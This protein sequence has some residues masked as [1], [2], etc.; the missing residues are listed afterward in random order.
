MNDQQISENFIRK[1]TLPQ[2]VKHGLLRTFRLS[3]NF[4]PIR[5]RR[6]I[7]EFHCSSKKYANYK[8]IF[9]N[10]RPSV[11]AETT[12]APRLPNPRTNVPVR[13]YT[14]TPV[15]RPGPTHNDSLHSPWL[16][17]PIKVLLSKKK[18]GTDLK[19]KSEISIPTT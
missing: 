15:L 8:S 9:K 5:P 2:S 6:N 4:L 1:S 3:S 16:A 14:R 10:E 19:K 12:P 7:S 17:K 18:L 11:H 13:M